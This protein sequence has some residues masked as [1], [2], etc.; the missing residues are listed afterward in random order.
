[1]IR[2]AWKALEL[3]VLSSI[4]DRGLVIG[5]V[6]R[7]KG[8]EVVCAALE[9]LGSR[10]PLVDWVGRDTAYATRDGSTIAHLKERYPQAWG[11]KIAHYQ[12]MPPADVARRQRSARFNL[13]ASTWDVFNFT[14]VEAMAS[15]RP[16]IVS[17]GAGASELVEDGINGYRFEAGDP[18]SL[19]AA[20]ERVLSEKPA[21]LAEIGHAAQET[22]RVSL[23]PQ[24]IVAQR[25]AAYRKTIEAFAAS[26]PV[27]ATSWIGDICRPTRE[28]R[29][30]DAAF[31]EHFPLR[32]LT[33]HVARRVSRRIL[34]R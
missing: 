30:G 15:G 16:T 25:L 32:E 11:D 6:Q 1:M 13:V 31:L 19:A 4:S 12:P 28:A 18:D 7:W 33:S 26:P 8:P 21:R 29:A 17:S 24:K 14:G 20:I 23:D 34:S 22:V 3:P 9:S 27:A 10:T 2:P 5:R